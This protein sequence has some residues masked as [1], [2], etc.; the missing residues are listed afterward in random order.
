MGNR[1]KKVVTITMSQDM[2]TLLDKE[3]ADS[4]LNRSQ[5]IRSIFSEAIKG[6]Y[7]N[8][9]TETKKG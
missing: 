2:L 6:K 5:Y 9:D 3:C 7:E 8:T 1:I 4:N